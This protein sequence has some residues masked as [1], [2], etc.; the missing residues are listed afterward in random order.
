MKEIWKVEEWRSAFEDNISWE[1]GNWKEIRFWKDKMVDN[2][3]LKTKFPRL[4]SLSI[5]K[6]LKLN[7]ARDCAT[8]LG[9]GTWNGKGVCLNG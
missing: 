1:I 6:D 2:E 4:I 8:T 5:N 3:D 7:Q 9:S